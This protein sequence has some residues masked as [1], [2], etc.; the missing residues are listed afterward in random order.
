MLSSLLWFA[1]V[2][3][4]EQLA[5]GLVFTVLFQEVVR[6]LYFFLIQ[7]IESGL[8]SKISV[9]QADREP[10]TT[11]Y[12]ANSQADI[13]SDMPLVASKKGFL[14]HNLSAYTAGLGFALMG[15]ITEYIFLFRQLTGPG[16]PMEGYR[17]GAFFLLA[18]LDS[19]FMAL[20]QIS[21]S[22]LLFRA[23][24]LRKYFQM[25]L[26]IAA[27]LGLSAMTLINELA[28]PAPELLCALLAVSFLGFLVW[29]FFAA[30]G[31]IR[32]RTVAHSE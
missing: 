4:R 20:S 1:V 29:A 26:V 2:P 8:R 3:L 23:Y 25:V 10:D 7:K 5:F 14:N 12:T 27:H 15:C 19:C 31:A 6:F 18:A 21:W 11:T 9:P 13:D 17:P 24:R 22:I 28:S 16:T 32:P 30:G